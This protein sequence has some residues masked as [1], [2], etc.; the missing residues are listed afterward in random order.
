MPTVQ[1]AE[2]EGARDRNQGRRGQG[3]WRT[4]AAYRPGSPGKG[5]F[6]KE[7]SV[8]HVKHGSRSRDIKME[9][10][11]SDVVTKWSLG[12]FRRTI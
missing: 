9:E 3:C 1:G 10:R 11:L 8:G 6:I 12:D 7:T 5:R 4:G 2:E